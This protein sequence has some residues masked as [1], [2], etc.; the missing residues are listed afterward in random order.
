MLHNTIY[1]SHT[2]THNTSIIII[3]FYSYTDTN[4]PNSHWWWHSKKKSIKNVRPFLHTCNAI[5]IPG[6]EYNI[7]VMNRTCTYFPLNQAKCFIF[8]SIHKCFGTNST[9]IRYRYPIH[10]ILI[11]DFVK[12]KLLCMKRTLKSLSEFPWLCIIVFIVYCIVLYTCF[13]IHSQQFL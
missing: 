7:S 3:S 4:T 5:I 10:P 9:R 8:F 2:H 13:I 12:Y 6:Q 11:V 1:S